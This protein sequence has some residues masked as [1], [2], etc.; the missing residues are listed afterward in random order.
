MQRQCAWCLRFMDSFGEPVSAPQPK[1]YEVS[2]GMCRICGLL[3]LEQALRDTDEQEA[4]RK[5]V[6]SS[7]AIV[8][9]ERS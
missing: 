5:N 6:L 1:R 2:H 3:W 4:K 8:E 7:Q 9:T